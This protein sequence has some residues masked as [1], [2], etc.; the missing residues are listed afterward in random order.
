MPQ[1]YKTTIVWD[2]HTLPEAIRGAHST[3]EGTWGL[4]HVLEG[5]ARLVF[6]DPAHTI[7]VTPGRPAPISPQVIHHVEL[8]G[9]ARLQV[10]FYREPPLED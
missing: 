4:L 3:K 7:T 6:H 1:P 10:E 9:P 5:S 2:E 8:D